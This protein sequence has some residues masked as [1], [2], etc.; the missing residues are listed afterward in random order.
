[1]KK[2][3]LKSDED[4]G[5]AESRFYKPDEEEA[6]IIDELTITLVTL[7]SIYRKMKNQKIRKN[8]TKR[9]KRKKQW[10]WNQTR[11]TSVEL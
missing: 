8:K 10:N 11:K 5:A 1:M 4:T 7:F 6:Q 9:K 3:K 2:L